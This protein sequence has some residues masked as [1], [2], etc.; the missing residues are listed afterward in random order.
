MTSNQVRPE[1]GGTAS[2]VDFMKV[3]SMAAFDPFR[4]FTTV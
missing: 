2:N 4:T 3:I 1:Q